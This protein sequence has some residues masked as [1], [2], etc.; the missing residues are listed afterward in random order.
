MY[1]VQ[2][3]LGLGLLYSSYLWNESDLK[4]GYQSSVMAH[5]DITREHIVDRILYDSSNKQQMKILQ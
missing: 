2:A 5:T 1:N 4:Q 3:V